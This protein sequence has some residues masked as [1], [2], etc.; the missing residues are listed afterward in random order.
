[1]ITKEDFYEIKAA[2]DDGVTSKELA[3]MMPDF[4]HEEIN[5]V[6]IA[7]SWKTFAPQE[8]LNEEKRALDTPE[9]IVESAEVPLPE[10][11]PRALKVVMSSKTFNTPRF[12][13]G[14]PF[15]KNLFALVSVSGDIVRI[16]DRCLIAKNKEDLEGYVYRYETIVPCTVSYEVPII[17]KEAPEFIERH[18]GD[19]RKDTPKGVSEECDTIPSA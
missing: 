19:N 10:K 1:M 7:S 9:P 18:F 17:S 5:K 12:S 13:R 6:Y 16:G 3:E 14:E 4:S 2:Q 8:V 15:T 11:R